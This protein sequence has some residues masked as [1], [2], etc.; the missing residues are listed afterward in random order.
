[1]TYY[2][3]NKQGDLRTNTHSEGPNAV[4]WGVFPGKEIIQPTVV[5]AISFMAWK[6]SYVW[7]GAI[8]ANVATQ[9]EAYELGVKWANIYEAGSPSRNLMMEVIESSYLVNVVHND[10]KDPEAIFKPFFKAGA[11]YTS[12]HSN[13]SA[14]LNGLAN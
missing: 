6:V 4:T 8:F 14:A 10:F 3:I 5:E 2:V 1:M 9:D 11:E 7:F 13:G 12:Q